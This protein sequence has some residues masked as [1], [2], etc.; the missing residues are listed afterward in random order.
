M[1]RGCNEVKQSVNTV[2]TESWVTLDSVFFGENVIVL[3]LQIANNFL[4][5]YD[6]GRF[7]RTAYTVNKMTSQTS[8]HFSLSML[9]PNPGVSTMVNEI[10]SRKG[11]GYEIITR[12]SHGEI[13]Y[14]T[15]SSSSSIVR[16]KN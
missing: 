14:L 16:K 7:V 8:Y 12:G 1:A 15:P 2:I 9:S 6:H 11:V 10:L 4:E 13:R 5:A 3:A